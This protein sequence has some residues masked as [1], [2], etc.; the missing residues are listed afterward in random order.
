[1]SSLLTILGAVFLCGGMFASAATAMTCR[2]FTSDKDDI[3]I[4]SCIGFVL[5]ACSVLFFAVAG[6]V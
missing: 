6:L 2:S 1:M 4:G 5:I 3:I